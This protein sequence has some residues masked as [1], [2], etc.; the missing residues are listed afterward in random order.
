M[1]A[2]FV[3]EQGGPESLVI[4]DLPE[5]EI[6]PDEVLVRVRAAALN[7]RDIFYREGSHGLKA[8]ELPF[9]IG[10]DMAGEVA[11]VGSVVRG[12]KI[13]DRV[14]GEAIAGAYAEYARCHPAE[15][16]LIP[17]WLS[18]EEAAAIPVVFCTSWHMLLCKAGLSLGETA[19]IMAGGSGLGS[20]GIQIAKRAGAAVITTAGSAD[21]LERALA[22]GAD[23]GINY[24]EEDL[25]QRVKEITNGRGVDVVLE[26]IGTPVW[27]GCFASMANGGRFVI[28]G[29][30]AG[31]RVQLHLGQLWTRELTLYG[32][33]QAPREDLAKVAELVAQKTFK[34]VV[35]R[36]FPLEEVAEAHKLMESDMFFGKIVLK[37]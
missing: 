24:K 31:H 30:S 19:L 7:R 18:Y 36:V 9:I 4:G 8:N 29:V 6:G 2:V 37:V 14:M 28:C 13:G 22:L 1:K 17:E 15:L 12:F 21:K 20:A 26:H 5:P 10:L 35:D 27:E 3:V 32:T 34:A 23:Y 33:R 11:A 16:A 25:A